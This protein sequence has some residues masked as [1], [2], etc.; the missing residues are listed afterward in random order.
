[1]A[2]PVDDVCAQIGCLDRGI[3]FDE[4]YSEFGQERCHRRTAMLA[5]APERP[6]SLRL[7]LWRAFLRRVGLTRLLPTEPYRG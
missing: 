4:R 7:G 5:G 6:Y 2:E 1:M 3:C